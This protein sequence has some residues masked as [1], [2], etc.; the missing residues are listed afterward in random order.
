M[1]IVIVMVGA[2]LMH[3]LHHLEVVCYDVTGKGKK[4]AIFNLHLKLAPFSNFPPT[5]DLRAAQ[6]QHIHLSMM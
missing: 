2:K 1:R 4:M 5:S 6:H 3:C